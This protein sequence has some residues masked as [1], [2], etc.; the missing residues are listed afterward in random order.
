VRRDTTLAAMR[1]LPTAPLAAGCLILG[2]GVALASGSRT[3]GGVV[4]LAGGIPCMR[5]WMVRRGPRVASAL[6]GVALAVFVA[7]HVLGFVIGA[8]PAVLLAAATM[9]AAAWIYGDAPALR[10]APRDAPSPS[11][12]V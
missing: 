11:N 3:L 1:Q 7:A 12:K 10:G 2:F 5:A 9:G 4:L 6:T 8:W